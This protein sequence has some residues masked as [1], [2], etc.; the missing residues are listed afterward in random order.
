[1][2]SARWWPRQR[3][4]AQSRVVGELTEVDFKE[5][6]DVKKGDLL[7]VIDPR[8]YQVALAQAEAM[9]SRDKAQQKDAQLDQ[10]R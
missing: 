3:C 2:A 1:M 7:A 5:G 9:L 10:Q 4:S 6:Q 8:P